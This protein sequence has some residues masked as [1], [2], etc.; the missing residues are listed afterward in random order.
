MSQVISLRLKE[1]Q[2]ERLKRM[3]RRLGR[4]ASETG[5]RLVEEG[6]RR[7]EFGLIDFRDSAAGR[8]AHVQGGSLA[9][10][11]VVMV[12]RHYQMDAARTAEHLEWPEARVKAALE[13]ASAFPEEIETALEDHDRCDWESLSRLLPEAE[14][15]TVDEGD[16][17][18]APAEEGKQG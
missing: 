10:W 2:I 16:G 3:A 9:V 15:V 4:S 7:S 1:D 6:L 14:L 13:Y 17:V 8:Q 18:G 12:A 5:V 11:E